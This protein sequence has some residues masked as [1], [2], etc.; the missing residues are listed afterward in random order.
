MPTLTL[1]CCTPHW[2]EANCV[3]RRLLSFL[4]QAC[5]ETEDGKCEGI[6]EPQQP[7]P[8]VWVSLNLT[9]NSGRKERRTLAFPTSQVL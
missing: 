5:V 3:P 2:S 6:R 8:S 1:S 4:A 9:L 7:Q